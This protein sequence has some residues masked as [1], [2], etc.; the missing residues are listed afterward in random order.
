MQWKARCRQTPLQT[1]AVMK[2]FRQ[3]ENVCDFLSLHEAASDFSHYVMPTQ[4][5]KKLLFLQKM[6]N[7]I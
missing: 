6:E 7:S 2:D 4:S 1:E 3:S 5:N